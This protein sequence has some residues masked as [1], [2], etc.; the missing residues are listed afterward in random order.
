[1][2][3]AQMRDIVASVERASGRQPRALV[4]G[5][6]FGGLAAAIRLQAAGLQV[7][8]VEAREGPGGRASQLRLDGFTFDMGPTLITA[9]VLLEDLW[10]C[11][12][13]ELCADV[14]LTPLSPFY[15]I[16]FHDGCTFDSWG[17]AGAD[18]A[19]IARFEPRDVA[20]Y[21]TFLAAT[22]RIYQ[23]AFVELARQPFLT[24]R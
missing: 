7:T 12:G 24:T 17:T 21:R 4:I 16:V 10:R 14:A 2:S 11:A 18:E 9:P 13:R 20:G 23:R 6:G 5:A 8:L 3:Q 1:M 19:E 15:R 22:Q